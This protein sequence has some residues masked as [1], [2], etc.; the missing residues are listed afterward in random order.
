V[1][2]RF[3]RVLRLAMIGAADAR[4]LMQMLQ[5]YRSG[6]NLRVRVSYTCAKA[7]VD[8]NLGEE[9]KVRPDDTLMTD[10]GKWL[11]PENVEVVY[12]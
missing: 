12:Q 1:R 5:P 10:L 4:K 8:F 2:E 3:G 11:E 7:Q 9:W 6:G